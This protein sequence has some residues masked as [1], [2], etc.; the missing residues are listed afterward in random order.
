E[1]INRTVEALGKRARSQHGIQ[2]RQVDVLKIYP[3]QPIDEIAAEHIKELP[4]TLR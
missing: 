4:R 1:R 2:L 3:S